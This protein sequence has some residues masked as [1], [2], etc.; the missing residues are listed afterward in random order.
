MRLTKTSV[1]SAAFDRRME[2]A[3]TLAEYHAGCAQTYALAYKSQEW[4]ATFKGLY[5]CLTIDQLAAR[6]S[7]SRQRVMAIV[8][9]VFKNE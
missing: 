4:V 6:Y 3:P 9:E 2:R 1:L 7:L 5:L 8:N